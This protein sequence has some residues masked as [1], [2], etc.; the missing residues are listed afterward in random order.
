MFFSNSSIWNI[1][2]FSWN[3]CVFLSVTESLTIAKASLELTILLPPTVESSL[4]QTSEE[5]T[6]LAWLQAQLQPESYKKGTRGPFSSVG[7]EAKSLISSEPVPPSVSENNADQ[8]G[9]LWSKARL[10]SAS[11]MFHLPV[12]T[13]A[14]Q[15]CFDLY[16][17]LSS[18]TVHFQISLTAKILKWEFGDIGNQN[19]HH[20]E[21]KRSWK[22][23]PQ[24]RLP[25]TL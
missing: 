10:V 23:W 21:N 19:Q 9:S 4:T 8:W 17:H 25:V 20:L 13:L 5:T 22:D 3:H 16:I 6:R 15:L 12:V 7:E 11:A 1:K 14:L 2:H 24:E 18:V